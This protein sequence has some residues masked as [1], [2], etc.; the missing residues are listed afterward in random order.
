VIYNHDA[1]RVDKVD[2]FQLAVT[3]YIILFR[4][5]PF[6]SKKGCVYDSN[7]DNLYTKRPERFYGQFYELSDPLERS[8]LDLILICFSPK[9]GK[10][11]TIAEILE[12]DYISAAPETLTEDLQIELLRLLSLPKDS[13]EN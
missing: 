5:T 1:Y 11:V 12:N 13:N 7:Y 9:A 6:A 3:L 10:R 2:I 4:R 8:L